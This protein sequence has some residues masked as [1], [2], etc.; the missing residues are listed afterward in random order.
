[1]KNLILSLALLLSASLP[2]AAS[3]SSELKISV[4]AGMRVE[5][6]AIYVASRNL[7]APNCRQG[8]PF[9]LFG[10]R[11]SKLVP[12]AASEANGVLTV[13]V[14]NQ[15]NNFCGYAFDGG[16]TLGL[17]LIYNGEQANVEIQITADGQ[18]LPSAATA[19]CGTEI[20]LGT[21][22]FTCTEPS[23]GFSNGA[24]FLNVILK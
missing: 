12:V 15:E 10:A 6:F 3:E 9:Q 7:W 21:P 2:A 24:A 13:S 16:A 11:A 19:E 8:G 17:N 22:V 1:M 14:P 5:A 20:N 18:G 4:P 23:L